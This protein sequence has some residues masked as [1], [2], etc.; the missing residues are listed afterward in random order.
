NIWTCEVKGPRKSRRVHGY[1]LSTSD[2]LFDHPPS[3]NPYL[4][5][6]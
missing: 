6:L 3:D 2:E 4:K 5:L 1:L